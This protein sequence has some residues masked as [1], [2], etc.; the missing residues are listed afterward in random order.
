MA[1][2]QQIQEDLKAAMKAHDA[3]KL[4]AVR[5][6]KSEIL[7]GK[8]AENF[9]GE[10]TDADIVKM[11]QKLVKQRNESASQYSAAG[12]QELADNELAEA[13]AMDCYLP[14]QLTEAEV[15]ERLKA[16]IA[17]VGASSPA[18][19]GKVMGK[20][21]KALAGQADGRMISTIVK[22]LLAQ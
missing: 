2:E 10:L 11:I 3:V 20:A 12:R 17:E 4:A 8:T 5:A 14:K 15:E 22:R 21:S 1:L 7:L 16:I 6:I 13:A 19:M 18:D 9:S